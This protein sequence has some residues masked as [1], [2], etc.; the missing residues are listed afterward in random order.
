MK[1][2]NFNN[3]KKIKNSRNE[4]YCYNMPICLFCFEEELTY[5]IY[6]I[7]FLLFLVSSIFISYK[8]E[9]NILCAFVLLLCPFILLAVGSDEIS[10]DSEFELD[11]PSVPEASMGGTNDDDSEDDNKPDRFAVRENLN[12]SFIDD[13]KLKETLSGDDMKKYI[14]YQD[15][16]RRLKKEKIDYNNIINNIKKQTDDTDADQQ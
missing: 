12:I 8:L 1:L 16:S 9:I 4:V 11:R 13:E 5:E 6:V 2:N 10:P 15:E 7:F 3:L 14:I